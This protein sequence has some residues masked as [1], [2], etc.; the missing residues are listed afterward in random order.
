[1]TTPHAAQNQSAQSGAERD[2][3]WARVHTGIVERSGE[4]VA[5]V[6]DGAHVES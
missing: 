4:G 2:R 3:D 6:S 1:M 5:M